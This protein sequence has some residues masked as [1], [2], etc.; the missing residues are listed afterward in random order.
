MD[1]RT[2]DAMAP[3]LPAAS[4][5]PPPTRQQ[6][7]FARSTVAARLPV[8]PLLAHD[9]WQYKAEHRQPTGSFKVRGALT[10]LAQAAL[11]G[12][13]E[14]IAASAGNH[15]AAVAWAAAQLGIRATI[16]VPATC[17]AIKRRKM[18][19]LAQVIVHPSAG[20]DEAQRHAQELAAARGVRFVSPYD[21]PWVAAGNGAS[22]MHEILEQQ[23]Y[24][25]A[26]VLPVGGGGLMTGVLAVLDAYAPEVRVIP[27]QS[28][29]SPA[30]VRSLAD[31]A[32]YAQWPAAN[33][34][35]EGLEGGAGAT[36]V[37]M[38]KSHG[39][40]GFAV[41]EQEIR[42]AM[43][44]LFA[45]WGAP[46]EGSAAVVEAVRSLPDLPD[47][48]PHPVAILTGGNVAIETLAHLQNETPWG[49]TAEHAARS[50]D[51][52]PPPQH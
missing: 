3:P 27:V 37:A 45:R 52:S 50:A 11:Q 43:L 29:A 32:C 31:N 15:G 21:D 23:P 6:I 5:A 28:L 35:A 9:G 16:V 1:T 34:L 51:S 40:R 14:V 8:T 38:A 4:G 17:P 49:S 24:V 39:L 33:T 7:A 19:Q 30:F 26:V 47:L 22:M 36:A 41:C 48:G 18:E 2:T 44:D 13:R 25:S 12:N 46:I 10:A 42:A 20:Y